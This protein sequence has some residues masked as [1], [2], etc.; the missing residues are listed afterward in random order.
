MASDVIESEVDLRRNTAGEDMGLNKSSPDPDTPSTLEIL[1]N[2]ATTSPSYSSECGEEEE[3]EE[4]ED[5]DKD[6]GQK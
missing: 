4:E 1:E 5:R 3:E 6:R 2:S